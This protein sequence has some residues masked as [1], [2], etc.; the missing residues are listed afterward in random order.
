MPAPKPAPWTPES[1]T[2]LG[3]LIVITPLCGYLFGCG[4]A[5][6]WSGFVENCNY[7]DPGERHPCPFCE[8]PALSVPLL[9][10]IALTGLVV[11]RTGISGM[12]HFRRSLL[13]DS[14]GG[15]VVFVLLTVVAGSLF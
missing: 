11:T 2:L 15:L 6:P 3:I 8:R 5:W 12:L 14:Q 1:I 7:F 4:C 9:S 10:A 13:L